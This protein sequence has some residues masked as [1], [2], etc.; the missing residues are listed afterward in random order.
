MSTSSTTQNKV[1]YKV[2]NW[3]KYNKSLCQRGSLTL[4]I[5]ESVLI[6]WELLKDKKKEVGEVVYPAS[7]INLLSVDKNQLPLMFSPKYRLFKQSFLLVG[8]SIFTHTRLQ[9]FMPPPE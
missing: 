1:S 5:E 6:E 7:I 8:K 2:R 3:K 4:W 9:H